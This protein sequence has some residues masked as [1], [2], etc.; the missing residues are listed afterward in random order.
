MLLKCQVSCGDT[1]PPVLNISFITPLPSPTLSPSGPA[2]APALDN[3]TSCSSNGKQIIGERQTAE[4]R[5]AERQAANRL[6]MSLQAEAMSKGIYTSPSEGRGLAH[7][8][9]PSG[10]TTSIGALQGLQPWAPPNLNLSPGDHAQAPP[11]P[12]A[13][14][15]ITQPPIASPIC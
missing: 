9:P 2:P 10:D 3:F 7:P 13:H 6:M 4:E 8:H 12:P 1:S 14:Y 15:P 5:E 11:P